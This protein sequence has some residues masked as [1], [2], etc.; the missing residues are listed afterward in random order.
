VPMP[1]TLAALLAG[2]VAIALNIAALAAADLV[3]LATARGGLLHLLVMLS[4]WPNR[5]RNCFDHAMNMVCSS[6][7]AT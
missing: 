3:P 7:Q 5:V 4:Q 2:A 1:R 6:G